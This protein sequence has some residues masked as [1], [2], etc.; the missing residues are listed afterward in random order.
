MKH[1][2]Q[3]RPY[4]TWQLISA[5]WR[6]EHRFF[7]YSFFLLACGMTVAVVGLDVCFSYWFNHF[8][9]S[10]QEYDKRGAIDLLIIFMFLASIYIIIQ[11]YR[12]Y[13]TQYLGLRWRRWLTDQFLA[14]WL[15]KRSYYYLENFDEKTD[16]PDQRIQEDVGALVSY[17]LD[18]SMGLLGSLITFFSFI[19]ILWS[20]SGVINLPLGHFGTLHIPGYLVWVG[21]VYALIGT[22]FTFKIGRPLVQLNFEQQRREANF[23]YA[24]IDLRTHA[25]NVALYRGEH[26]QETILSGLVD[27]FLQNW[28]A[29][30]L[31]QKLLLWFTAGYNQISVMVPLLVALP[32]YFGKMFKLGGLIQS[33]QS[34]GKI[35]DALSFIV[36]SYTT[37]A[38]W[39]A[40]N[41]RLV[42]FLNHITE[43]EDRATKNNDFVFHTQRPNQINVK[44]LVVKKP[45][46]TVLLDGINE[47]FIHGQNY[48]LQG[49]SGL[50]K[51]TF[52]RTIAGI[53]PCGSGDIT[54]PSDQN[55]MY[56]PQKSYM[57]IG[58]L[59]EAL[60]FPDKIRKGDTAALVKV[61]KDVQLPH[62]VTRLQDVSMWSEQLSPGE[63][64]RISIARVLLQKPDWVFLDE[65]T[66][67]L[68]L[69][70]EKLMFELLRTQ[71]PTCSIVSVGHRTSLADYHEHQVNMAK[72]GPKKVM[73]A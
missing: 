9:D 53:W 10:L 46:G 39:Q 48:L 61:L 47:D 73:P 4:T 23:R 50:G 31:R 34:F 20:L 18:L 63:L 28:Y 6:S 41:R 69:E 2:F 26:H 22:Y 37:I 60:L 72:Y 27:K 66:S 44:K 17:S 35:Q 36:N 56:L 59:E 14:R 43:V 49:Y 33:L 51:S 5:F 57:P 38:Q 30:I 67:A 3:A 45:D 32:N 7:A 55:M 1:Y 65:A 58:T 19:F 13:V 11:V 29:I 24:A 62:L 21:I 42:T 25:E 12:Y 68:D 52:I 15:E 40:V 64:Q 16:N 54:M 71:L 8:Y 70:N